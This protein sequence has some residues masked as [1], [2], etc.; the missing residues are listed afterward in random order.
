MNSNAV[1]LVVFFKTVP[2]PESYFQVWIIVM[3]KA[4]SGVKGE[5]AQEARR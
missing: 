2:A 3:M 5:Q 4:K 1:M